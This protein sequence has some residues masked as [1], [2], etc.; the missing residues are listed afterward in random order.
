M[1][2]E[3]KD[4]IYVREFTY[5][6]RTTWGESRVD[7]ENKIIYHRKH[8]FDNKGYIFL[9]YIVKGTKNHL[10]IQLYGYKWE[11]PKTS[12]KK[13]FSHTELRDIVHKRLFGQ[14]KSFPEEYTIV[15]NGYDYLYQI[16]I[17]KE[18]WFDEIHQRFATGVAWLDLDEADR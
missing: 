2:L 7:E 6:L 15:R 10:F 14:E 9:D 18:E 17:D 3:R 5:E 13:E 8:D 4:K 11:I 1:S 12:I 16:V